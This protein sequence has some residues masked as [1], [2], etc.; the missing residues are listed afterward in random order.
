MSD[1]VV[2]YFKLP[3]L[4]HRLRGG[5][6]KLRYPR[7]TYGQGG[8]RILLVADGLPVEDALTGRFLDGRWGN[9]VSNVVDRAMVEENLEDAEFVA[10]TTRLTRQQSNLSDAERGNN[11]QTVVRRLVRYIRKWQPDT[12]VFLGH[13]TFL[14]YW[15]PMVRFTE[16]QY[17][18]KQLTM[19]RGRLLPAKIGKHTCQII[20]SFSPK[21]FASLDYRDSKNRVNLLGFVMYDIATALHGANRY[22][23]PQIPRT[24]HQIITTIKQFDAWYQQLLAC[25]TPSLDTEGENLNRVYGN[26]LFCLLSTFDGQTAQMVPLYHPQTPFTS[27][28]LHYISAKLRDYFEN[29]NSR[30][31]IFQNAK[32]DILIFFAELKIRHFRH[33]VYDLM[34]G[35]FFL[36]E[37]RKF[38]R[39]E[40]LDKAYSLE[41]ISAQYG[42]LG[43]EHS[44]IAKEDR[45]RMAEFSLQQIMDYGYM[46]VCFHPDTHVFTEQGPIKIKELIKQTNP[47]KVLS[48]NHNTNSQEYKPIEFQS[49]H[50]TSKQMVEIQYEGGSLF[51]TE[52]HEIWSVTRDAYI[53]ATDIQPD[54]ELLIND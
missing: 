9:T 30:Y 36:D 33:R 40:Q 39:H 37:N 17:D 22:T 16:R 32:F 34:T 48:F 28:E 4:K 11:N 53:R 46:D 26:K 27:E 2:K 49:Q 45:G 31:V 54:E 3:P 13:Q 8:K 10:V 23:I 47:P 14:Q 52:D 35:E 12:V 43:Y 21:A 18:D 1:A 51:I 20:L 7:I 44:P 19:L 15:R 41:F 24:G 50:T 29:G 25:P 38:F 5:E 42:A 6:V